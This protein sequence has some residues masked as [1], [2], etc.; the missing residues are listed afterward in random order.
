MKK[1][2]FKILIQKINVT[3]VLVSMV[4]LL[5]CTYIACVYKT[6]TIGSNFERERIAFGELQTAVGEKEHAYIEKTSIIDIDEAIRLGYEKSNTAA[7]AY[8]DTTEKDVALA[9]R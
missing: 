3:S 5:S 1:N 6:V 8:I 4:L 2:T 7:I 9:L